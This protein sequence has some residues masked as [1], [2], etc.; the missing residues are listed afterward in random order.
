MKEIVIFGSTVVLTPGILIAGYAIVTL[1][2]FVP[3]HYWN[4]SEVM[5]SFGWALFWPVELVLGLL[6]GI[7]GLPFYV[8]AKLVDRM[9]G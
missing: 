2:L 4:E 3:I 5:E 1:I 8:L 6:I 9:K 7:I